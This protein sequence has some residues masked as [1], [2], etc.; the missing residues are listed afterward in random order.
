HGATV[1][2]EIVVD[3]YAEIWIDGKLERRLGDAGGGVVSGFNVPN[4]AILTRDA[5]A[6]RHF[7]LAVFAMNGPI[8]A[9]PDNF[10]WVRSATLEVHPKPAQA[11][12]E[13]DIAS[14]ERRDAAIGTIFEEGVRVEK[15]AAGFEFTEGPVWNPLE[16]S[17]LFSDPNQNTIF[18]YHPHDAISVFRSKSGYKGVDVGRYKQPGS[19][20]LALDAEGRIT[21]NEHGNRRVTRL[22]PTGQ[23]TVLAD[24]YH[25]KR[26]N[27]PNDLVYRS[28]G[29]LYFTDPP[30]GLPRVFDDPAKELAFSGVYRWRSGELTLLSRELQ[31]PNGLAFSPDERYL[32]VANWDLSRKVVMRFPVEADGMLGPGSVFFDMTAAPGEEAL[33]GLKVDAAGNVFV[34]G[35]G[36]IWV[37]SKEGKHLGTLRVAELPANFAWGDADRRSLYMTARTGLYRVRTKVA[38]AGAFFR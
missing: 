29:S 36:G 9:A 26:L 6:G 27:S 35:P 24:S 4:R 21:I 8:S 5:R 38:G 7:T 10:L 15:L 3:D 16:G 11:T 23:L 17:L 33:D 37:L 22:E 28:D 30:F 32:Y 31:G 14:L 12:Q 19:N 25:G 20:G 18:R 1:A 13:A 34:S 2:F